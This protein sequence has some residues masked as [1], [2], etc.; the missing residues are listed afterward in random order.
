MGWE[1]DFQMANDNNADTSSATATTHQGSVYSAA[2]S[3]QR[4]FYDIADDPG[5]EEYFKDNP[6]QRISKKRMESGNFNA[7]SNGQFH[8]HVPVPG[9]NGFC[10]S[11]KYFDSVE[12]QSELSIHQQNKRYFSKLFWY[13][14]P[15]PMCFYGPSGCL[16]ISPSSMGFS[17]GGIGGG[18]SA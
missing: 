12:T 14:I 16:R 9:H 6:A 13:L 8:P 15:V 2:K 18:G 4:Y 5:R 17:G 1:S 11:C 10:Q 7:R 3:I